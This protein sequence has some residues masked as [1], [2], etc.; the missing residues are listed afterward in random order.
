MKIVEITWVDIEEL[1]GGW[2]SVDALE[3][4]IVTAKSRTVKQVAYLYEE[5]ENQVVLV[6]SYDQEGGDKVMYGTIN[7]IPKGCIQK[8][9]VITDLKPA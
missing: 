1:S 7:V 2:H 5:D 3:E 4:F 9:E 8:M 6:D